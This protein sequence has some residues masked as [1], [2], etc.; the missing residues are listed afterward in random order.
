MGRQIYTAGDDKI[1]M[2]MWN[3]ETYEIDDIANRL[4]RPRKSVVN[5]ASNLRAMGETLVMRGTRPLEVAANARRLPV[6]ELPYGLTFKDDPS[7]IGPGRH[8]K[9]PVY[10]SQRR[11]A[12]SSLEI[13]V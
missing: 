11:S 12:S 9:K 8:V 2:E 6:F 13:N 4:L 1:L 7:A 3:N 10:E 5:R